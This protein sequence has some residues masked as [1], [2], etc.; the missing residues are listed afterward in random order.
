MLIT[1]T[2][3]PDAIRFNLPKTRYKS[4]RALIPANIRALLRS[5]RFAYAWPETVAL[6]AALTIA[7]AMIVVWALLV[8]CAGSVHD[9]RL[10]DAAFHWFASSEF[11]FVPPL[12][13]VLRA[14]RGAIR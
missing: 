9:T 6:G 12:W 4:G 7:I 3:T 8:I 10:N 5:I 14:V 2:E 13:L 11:T 1:V